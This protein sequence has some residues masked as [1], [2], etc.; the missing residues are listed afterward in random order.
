[1]YNEV[2]YINK[3][4]FFIVYNIVCIEAITSTIIHSSFIATRLVLFNLD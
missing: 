3:L 2:N 4:D 1:M